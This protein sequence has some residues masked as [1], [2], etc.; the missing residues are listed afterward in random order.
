MRAKW[1]K[2]KSTGV[3]R[4]VYTVQGTA[5]EIAEYVD[6]QGEF[7]R[8]LQEDGTIGEDETSTPVFY[9]TKLVGK[10]PTL[11]YDVDNER[12]RGEMTFEDACIMDAVNS[13]FNPSVSTSSSARNVTSDDA[14][15]AEIDTP[16]AKVTKAVSGKRSLKTS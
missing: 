9:S 1:L 14:D 15:D 7:C 8:F 11:R 2:M 5:K 4:Y 13:A 3:A 16:V 6:N 10:N 12:Y